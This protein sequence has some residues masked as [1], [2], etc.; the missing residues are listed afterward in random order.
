M[1]SEIL[2][3]LRKHVSYRRSCLNLQASENRLSDNALQAMGNDMYARYS[4]VT[5]SGENSYGGSEFSDRVLSE[6][7]RIVASLYNAEYAEVRPIGGHIAAETVLLS[8]LPKGGS[9]LYIGP[10]SGGYPG[11]DQPYLPDMLGYRSYRIPYDDKNQAID[12]EGLSTALERN[13]PDLIVLGQSAFVRPYDLRGVSQIASDMHVPIVYD[14]SHVMGL[15]AGGEFQ[16][17]ALEYCAALYGSTHKSFFGP[18]G[19]IILTNDGDLYNEIHRNTIWY[20][21]DNYH[22]SRVAALAIAADE[23]KRHGKD[24]A[25]ALAKNSKSL[26]SGLYELGWE[27]RFPPWFSYS[28]QVLLSGEFFS[29]R[30]ITPVQ[31]SQRMESNRIIVDRDSRIGLSEATRMGV[32][33][34]SKVASLMDRALQGV[35]VV[36][37]VSDLVSGLSMKFGD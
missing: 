34:M 27:V 12:L 1:A 35:K 10:E 33:D 37:E 36:Q 15:I 7:Q 30:K 16:P 19:G 4:H 23:M 14:G 2:E 18:Q 25:K 26:A 8:I 20:T 9:F 22:P 5:D 13:R 11:Y 21:M 24:Y 6:A 28:H 32:S 17:D 29:S 3:I 31:F